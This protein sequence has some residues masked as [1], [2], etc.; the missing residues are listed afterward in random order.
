M[1]KGG[2]WIAYVGPFPFPSGMAGSRRMLGV[3]LSFADAGIRVVVGSGEPSPRQITPL[4]K[5]EPSASVGYIGL[6][7]S[8]AKGASVMQKA[9]RVFWSWGTRTVAWLDAQPAKPDCV[10]VYGGARH[11]C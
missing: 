7:E 10:V 1:T 9:V 5:V 4:D 3:A 6:D 2:G 11:T 8:P